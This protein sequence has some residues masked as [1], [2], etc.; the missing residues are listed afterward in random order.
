MHAIKMRGEGYK[1]QEIAERLDTSPKVVSRWV[2]AYLN[3]GIEALSGSKYGGNHRNMSEAEENAFLAEYK[4]L[5]EKGQIIEVGTMKAAYEAK[6]GHPIGGTQI[7]YVL[8]RNGWRKV[9]PRSKHPNK[10]SEEEICSS[11]KLK[12]EFK[13]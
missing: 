2:S 10:A 3:E 5:A 12:L 9:L 4:N 8:H 11:K 1:N 7:Y 6:V 13:N